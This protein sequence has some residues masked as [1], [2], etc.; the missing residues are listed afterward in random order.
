MSGTVG[1]DNVKASVKFLGGFIA[2]GIRLF[3]NRAA[4]VAEV[5]D[6]QVDEVLDLLVTD[7]RQEFGE[8]LKAIQE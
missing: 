6:T 5:K 8:I 4:L 1:Y 2:G 7:V 3:K